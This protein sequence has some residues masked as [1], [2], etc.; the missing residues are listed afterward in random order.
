[1]GAEVRLL[2]APGEMKRLPAFLREDGL[3]VPEIKG[4]NTGSGGIWFGR[5]GRVLE[6]CYS[7]G[8]GG[9]DGEFAYFLGK[10]ICSRFKVEKA[11][12]D[13]VGYCRSI[14]EFIHGEPFVGLYFMMKRRK[15]IRSI[16]RQI[17]DY[18]S[19]LPWE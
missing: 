7:F 18:I 10:S 12:W 5:K 9:S 11:G 8:G 14:D 19:S 6:I 2:L 13:S 1:M 4:F 16:R 3:D 17:V 15:T